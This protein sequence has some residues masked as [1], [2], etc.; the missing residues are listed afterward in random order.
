M[1]RNFQCLRKPFFWPQARLI[2]FGTALLDEGGE[3]A[4][5]HSRCLVA[6]LRGAWCEHACLIQSVSKFSRCPL[7]SNE[8]VG[9]FLCAPA[10]FTNVVVALSNFFADFSVAAAKNG[11]G[12]VAELEGEAMD[13]KEMS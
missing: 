4:T 3:E 6:A 5:I 2:A 8:I 12:K 7:P 13:E 1:Y 9:E 10:D 11:G